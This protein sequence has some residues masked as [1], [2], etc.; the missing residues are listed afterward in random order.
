MGLFVLFSL[1]Q[2]FRA[3]PLGRSARAIHASTHTW[4]FQMESVSPPGLKGSLSRALPLASK[5]RSIV[6]VP[7]VSWAETR[8]ET[9]RAGIPRARQTIFS[10]THKKNEQIFL[11][12]F[13][14][15]SR[16]QLK[17]RSYLECGGVG[18]IRTYSTYI[19][20]EERDS[21]F[22]AHFHIAVSHLNG[23]DSNGF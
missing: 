19:E 8:L 7:F 12:I 6:N 11:T 21:Y 2:F 9:G 1:I 22:L 23:R 5:K 13:N 20:K 4:K 3:I 10:Q 17:L 18:R 15:N 16:F 14:L